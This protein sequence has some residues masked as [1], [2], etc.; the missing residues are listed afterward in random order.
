MPNVNV[1]LTSTA[2]MSGFVQLQ[3]GLDKLGSDLQKKIRI[4]DLGKSILG[5]LGFGS[6]FAAINSTV[7]AFFRG[8]EERAKAAEAQAQ[9]FK[10][11]VDGLAASAEK[12]AQTK[13]AN[14]IDGLAPADRMEAKKREIAALTAA[15][16]EEQKKYAAAYNAIVE[17]NSPTG[18]LVAVLKGSPEE[19]LEPGKGLNWMGSQAAWEAHQAFIARNMQAQVDAQ[20]RL[21]ELQTQLE[22]L[23]R[24]AAADSK[25]MI[26]PQTG[27]E[28]A[29]GASSKIPNVLDRFKAENAAIAESVRN[30][31]N[32]ALKPALASESNLLE[33]RQKQ[34]VEARKL[35]AA[36]AERDFA[37]QA[38]AIEAE[39]LLVQ[40]NNLLTE[41]EKRGKILPLLERENQLIADRI[42]ALKI[43][44]GLEGDPAAA[45][46]L[47]DR[48]DR[49]ERE[50]AQNAG[51]ILGLQTPDTLTNRDQKSLRDMS[52]PSQHYQTA[53]DGAA[54]GLIGFL[55]EAG[56]M[57][58]QLAEGI[59]STLGAAVSGIT[60]GIMGWVN[61]TM[62]FRQA[63]G[64]IGQSILQ[65]ML[66]T[67]I[68][69]GVQWLIN[70]ALIKTGM[71][72]IEATGDALRAARVAKENGAEAATLP[73]KTAGAAAAG[74]SSFGVAL[75]FGALAVALIMGLAAGFETGGFPSG[76][77]A[78]IRVNE[79][80]Q[81]SVLNARATSM[82]GRSGVDA[83]NAGQLF[84]PPDAAAALTQPGYVPNL[85]GGG[86][87]GSPVG[88]PDGAPMGDVTIAN[89]DSR[90]TAEQY[91]RSRPGRRI[92][93]DIVKGVMEEIA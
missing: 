79:N 83:L 75:A 69:M 70:A 90:P 45:Q 1:K 32:T 9:K 77:N 3:A 65:T 11:T 92:V 29:P 73:A 35:S 16:A 30:Y 54:G 52:D 56:T 87:G 71:L 48:I 28:V 55:T 50:K 67:I 60:Q 64:S 42:E 13:I 39:R 84:I 59:K 38:A 74:I 17:L 20:T 51:G 44:Q 58:D 68:Q 14:W 21:L 18:K 46:A 6:G 76:K 57:A 62:T 78:L 37:R 63:L 23:N 41:Q 80:G 24:S 22:A 25:R 8:F 82:L 88:G 10:D 72:S 91:L 15:I 31:L 2:D 66:Q 40:N 43:A 12:L 61:G 5:G 89:F 27:S 19:G 86:G 7:G 53:A 49:L 47:Q 4:P 36:L 85:G 26:D 33:A 93:A 34:T 81:E